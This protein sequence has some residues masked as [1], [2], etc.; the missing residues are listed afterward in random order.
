VEV[1]PAV[2]GSSAL[3]DALVDAINAADPFS[4]YLIEVQPIFD[5]SEFWRWAEENRGRV[6]SVKF[7]LVAPNGLF[8]ARNNL[9]DELKAANE[10]SGANEV[11]IELK[12]EDGLDL[13]T[14]PIHEAVDYAKGTGG[15][16]WGRAKGN[17]RYSSTQR[18]KRTTLKDGEDANEPLIVRAARHL[19]EILGR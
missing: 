4:P 8:G 9:R 17:K 11:V 15:R 14:P 10:Q 18:P 1:R 3:I 13:E 12:S 6:T 2:G 19:S 5:P 16:I 7:A